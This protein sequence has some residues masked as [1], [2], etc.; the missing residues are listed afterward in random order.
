M[1]KHIRTCCFIDCYR[2]SLPVKINYEY[3]LIEIIKNLITNL[4]V[5]HFISGMEIGFEQLIAEIVV[6]LKGKHPNITLEGVLPY[7]DFTIEWNEDQRDK[8][9]SLMEKIDKET[10]LQY[11]YTKDSIKNRNSYMINKSKYVVLLYNNTRE[12]YDL[13]LYTRSNKKAL[14]II[15]PDTLNIKPKIKVFK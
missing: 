2:G 10:L 1:A 7:E 5:T 4:Y 8:Y 11:H 15:E 9:Y 6:K 13:V 12:F 3:K 14:F